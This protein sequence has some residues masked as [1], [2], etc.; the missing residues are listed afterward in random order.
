MDRLITSEVG[1]PRSHW[2]E[3]PRTRKSVSV[4]V[5]CSR[6]SGCGVARCETLAHLLPVPSLSSE[7]R[8]YRYAKRRG[9]RR[10]RRRRRTT[11]TP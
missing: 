10:R 8:S 1:L 4:S 7:W 11:A 5:S 3:K 2:N 6:R 9:R